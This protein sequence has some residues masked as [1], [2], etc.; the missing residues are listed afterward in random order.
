MTDSFP[1]GIEG[2]IDEQ[3]LIADVGEGVS[4]LH[5][6]DDE[7][8]ADLV[9]TFLER[10]R[11][12]FTV[13][14]ET[15][16]RA[17]LDRLEHADV[18]C[19]VCDYD[20]PGLDGLEVLERVRAEYPDLPFV[21]FT[22]KGSEE[23]ASEAISKGVTEYLQ[24]GGGTEQYAVLANRIEQAVARYRAERQVTR[25][26]HAI[27]TAHDGI[28]LLDEG[29]QFIYVNEAY[30]DI[31]GYDREE[32]IGTHWDVLYPAGELDRAYNEMIPAAREGEW[33]G[34]TVY[35]RKD[36]DTVDVDHRITFTTDDTLICTITDVSEDE[37]VREELSLKERAMD[38]APIGI[39]ITDPEQAD[40][41]IVY[42]NDG[43]VELTGYAREEITGENCRFLQGEE[44]RAEP[45]TAMREA[46][47]DAEP[48]TVELRNY[49]ADGDL[50]WNRVSIAPIRGADGD[51]DYFVGF[52]EDVTE[53]HAIQ[54]RH[55][56]WIQLMRGFGDVLS[57]DLQTP[58]SVI[59]GRVELAQ[60]TGDVGH[61]EDIDEPIDR[62]A[63][64]IEDVAAVMET[65]ELVSD[66]AP[67]DVAAVAEEVWQTLEVGDAS[68]ALDDGT[69]T[70]AADEDA[71]RRLLENLLGNSLEHGGDAVTIRVG[72]L[73]GEAGF[74]VADDGPG[75]PEAERDDV[76]TPG[77]TTKEGGSGLGMAS[78]AQIVAA[79]G[80][81]IRVRDGIDGGARFE[82]VDVEA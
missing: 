42:A 69:P 63:A 20:M 16:P 74:Y 82:I 78:V 23:I 18:D 9:S 62:M 53:R 4:V 26:F 32:L 61:L 47:A 65:G 15:D 73:D 29:G 41:P 28:S 71:L 12:Y 38:E 51:P 57:H 25:G 43:F 49:R 58:L 76:F 34:R 3:G 55:E 44:T 2:A 54:E 45:V 79:H 11:D 40:N 48:V 19:V 37:A 77:F 5:I 81:E 60:E 21:L 36:G 35:V 33:R 75:I 17:A 50:F 31:T 52:Q 6:E 7:R 46:V 67:V 24:K 72:G 30:A 1:G 39:T 8:F 14:T 27:E 66:E 70:V 10:Q 68:L 80:W 13:E 64:L 59:R 56:E 22:G